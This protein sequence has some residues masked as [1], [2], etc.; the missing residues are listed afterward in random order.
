MDLGLTGKR[1][2]V[3]GSSSGI[4]AAVA[5]VLAA[6]GADVVVH[7]RDRDKLEVVAEKVR[8]HGHRVDLA[9]GDLATDEGA[10]GVVR[11][12]GAG[13][14]VDILVNNAGGTDLV[15]W[16]DAEP[17]LWA[18]AYQVNVVSAVRMIRAFVPAMRERGW[19]RVIQVGGG[20]ATQPIAMQPQY[21]AA[22]A[23]RH[24]LAVSL[25]RELKGTGVTSNVVS[26][27]PIMVEYMRDWL[28]RV[29]P[30]RGWGTELP[31]IERR[32][33]AEWVANDVGRYGTP[34]EVAAAVGYLA[35]RQADY[36]TGSVLRVD[37]GFVAAVS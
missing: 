5:D 19:G 7:G 11:A 37:G 14:P 16:F 22:L 10:A 27:G 28:A 33:A 23:A 4:G 13:G 29:G 26:P 12:A 20:L 35:S 1:A 9:L 32:A 21:S 2:L 31:E 8:G 25:A 34:E 18:A 15:P 36:V 6:E 24:N 3:T 30:E 17:D